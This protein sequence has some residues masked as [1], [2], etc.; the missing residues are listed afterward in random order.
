MALEKTQVE[1]LEDL[2]GFFSS[3][4]FETHV[5]RDKG[6]GFL[7]FLLQKLDFYGNIGFWRPWLG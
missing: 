1:V 2:L 5:D 4:G 6:E 3:L 7:A